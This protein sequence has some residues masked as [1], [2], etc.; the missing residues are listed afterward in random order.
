M[1]YISQWPQQGRQITDGPDQSKWDYTNLSVI[2]PASDSSI[3]VV[4]DTLLSQASNSTYNFTHEFLFQARTTENVRRSITTSKNELIKLQVKVIV[5]GN[6]KEG[7]Y[8]VSIMEDSEIFFGWVSKE[9]AERSDK[10]FQLNEMLEP[11]SFIT[12]PL[13]KIAGW[14]GLR[15]ERVQTRYLP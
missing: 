6:S 14:F 7:S 13:S 5:L 10:Q 9:Q 11:I 15:I 2:F 3:P 1:S 4:V 8:A 12:R